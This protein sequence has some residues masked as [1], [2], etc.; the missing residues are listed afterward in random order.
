MLLQVLLPI[1]LSILQISQGRDELLTSEK[2]RI[3]DIPLALLTVSI[4][5]TNPMYRRTLPRFWGFSCGSV[6][7]QIRFLLFHFED[8][9]PGSDYS[10]DLN[11]KFTK[12]GWT[13][14]AGGIVGHYAHPFDTVRRRLMMQSERKEDRNCRLFHQDCEV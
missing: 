3:K 6:H 14:M 9:H 10:E 12:F 2:E 8:L 11:Y 5:S 4:K 7:L 13:L 1:S